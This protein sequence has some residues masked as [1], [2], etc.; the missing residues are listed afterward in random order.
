MSR[1][2]VQIDKNSATWNSVAA[3]ATH[4]ITESAQRIEQRGFGPSE[5]EFER[6]RIAALRA[7]LA[8]P[9]RPSQIVA[10]PVGYFDEDE[11]ED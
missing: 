8:I 4:E 9:D 2:E 5:T 10:S 1:Q 6:G 7:L 3:W 11:D